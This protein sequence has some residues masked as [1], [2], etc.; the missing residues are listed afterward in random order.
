MPPRTLLTNCREALQRRELT[1][2]LLEKHS[3]RGNSI[4]GFPHKLIKSNTIKWPPHY[5]NPTEHR[6]VRVQ[7]LSLHI[8]HHGS[9]CSHSWQESTR[10]KCLHTPTLGEPSR[11]WINTERALNNN[12]VQSYTIARPSYAEFSPRNFISPFVSKSWV[13]LSP[14]VQLSSSARS[15]QLDTDPLHLQPPCPL[16]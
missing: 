10:A 1:P 4:L 12:T 11:A 15:H 6:L 16:R 5:K 9:H 14:W 2:I 13:Q 3:P 8:P 7:Y